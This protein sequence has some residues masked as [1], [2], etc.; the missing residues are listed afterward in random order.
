M[1]RAASLVLASVA[2]ASAQTWY[3]IAPDATLPGLINLFTLDAQSGR[4]IQVVAN[5][6]TTDNEYPKTSTLRCSYLTPVCW[7]ATGVAAPVVS[8]AIY[9]VNRT[10]GATL[11]KHSLAD[12]SK[13]IDNLIHDSATDALF[14]IATQFNAG[15]D[16]VVVSY[17]PATGAPTTLLDIT[18]ALNGGFVYGGAM[19]LCTSLKTMLLG[20]DAASGLQ[21]FVLAVNYA[22]RPPVVSRALP[23]LLPVPSSMHA[24]CNATDLTALLATTVQADSV[25]RETLLLGDIVNGFF[26]PVAREDLPTFSSRGGAAVFLTGLS[27]EFGGTIITPAYAPVARGP[28]VQP[29]EAGF[30]MVTEI[31]GGPNQEPIS[32]L[33]PINYFLAGAAGV[34]GV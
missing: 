8:D 13:F 2:V 24:F 20:V 5:V 26:L 7:F 25:E 30:L 15:N 3:G 10:S 17:D 6:R 31:N 29:P 4:P 1:Q 34:P 33:V 28:G 19:T 21:D 18:A 11:W 9:A 23:L 27:A 14:T 22:A 12:H 16:A 32:T